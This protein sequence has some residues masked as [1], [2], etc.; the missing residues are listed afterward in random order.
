MAKSYQ[1]V[2]ACVTNVPV[3]G[4]HGTQLATFYAGQPLPEGVPAD[5]VKHLLSVGL[6]KETG[7]E[8]KPTGA[9]PA[10][11]QQASKPASQTPANTGQQT[12]QPPQAPESVNGRSSKADLV[13]YG[14]AHGGNEAELDAL[15]REQLIER[16]VRNS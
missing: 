15:T 10:S 4:P 6:I 8:A 11:S 12:G 16:Y 2:G 5:R 9:T 14:V 3:A 7:G 13:A 1:V